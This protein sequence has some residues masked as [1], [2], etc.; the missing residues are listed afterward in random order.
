MA[1]QEDVGYMPSGEENGQRPCPR[2]GNGDGGKYP[3]L[4][5]HDHPTFSMVV[6]LDDG[7]SSLRGGRLGS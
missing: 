3:T 4:G 7:S 1:W 2:R 5:M 6:Y